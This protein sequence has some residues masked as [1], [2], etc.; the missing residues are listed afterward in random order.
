[1]NRSDLSTLVREAAMYRLENVDSKH[2]AKAAIYF[3]QHAKL[4]DD[5]LVILKFTVDESSFAG[6]TDEEI[7]TF[8]AE[9]F[10][11]HGWGK[12]S[13]WLSGGLFHV[14]MQ[15]AKSHAEFVKK[16]KIDDLARLARESAV[17]TVYGDI[18][19]PDEDK[20]F[21]LRVGLD[22][23]SVLE[24]MSYSE[25]RDWVANQFPEYSKVEVNPSSFG[26]GTIGVAL[27][28]E[29]ASDKFFDDMIAEG[30]SF[31]KTSSMKAIHLDLV[32][33]QRLTKLVKQNAFAASRKR[34]TITINLSQQLLELF[35]EAELSTFIAEQF[36]GYSVYVNTPKKDAAQFS[37]K[38]LKNE[39]TEL[40]D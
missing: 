34:D 11:E 20:Q 24:V 4:G 39:Q 30:V 21:M 25:F 9:Q 32:G 13:C 37:V 14:N 28:S 33:Y 26:C 18:D 2:W 19:V 15:E 40:T 1:M 31:V 27:L 10:P 29:G 23:D 6:M 12:I 16:C 35:S 5:D 17:I 36:P 22:E 8:I 3:P 7:Q 38:L